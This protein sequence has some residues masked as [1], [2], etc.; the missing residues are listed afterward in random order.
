M[1]GETPVVAAERETREETGYS[2]TA[3][4][5]TE[6]IIDYV[7]HW[8]GWDFDCRTHFFMAGLKTPR[9]S[10]H[11]PSATEDY[12][13]GHDWLTTEELLG[14]ASFHKELFPQLSAWIAKF[15]REW[16]EKN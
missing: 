1:D 8:A 11:P 7:F 3:D 12:I 16:A 4:E 9:N 15:Q 6:L 5:Q 2:V 14:A 10:P 13:E